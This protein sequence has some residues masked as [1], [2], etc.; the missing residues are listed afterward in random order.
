MPAVAWSQTNDGPYIRATATFSPCWSLVRNE[1]Y[2]YLTG[3]LEYFPQPHLSLRG[4]G[5][6]LAGMKDDLAFSYHLKHR[7][8]IFFGMAWHPLGDDHHLDPYLV[9][10]TGF[11]RMQPVVNGFAH[12]N[13]V[14]PL[15]TAGIG[16]SYYFS[17]YFHFFANVRWV[18]GEYLGDAP[19]K[20]GLYE[21]RGAAGLG[22]HLTRQAFKHSD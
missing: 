11:S 3:E 22:F 10:Q 14:S 2:S 21:I 1:T 20:I 4:E 17:K 13:A 5:S 7:E 19:Q 16:A 12:R 18:G 8:D 9:L 15:Q 6:Y